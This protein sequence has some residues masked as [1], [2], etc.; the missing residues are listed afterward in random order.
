MITD[1][2]QRRTF[3]IRTLGCKINQYESQALREAWLARGWSEV[4]M[5]RAR[6]VLF[7]SC[8]VTADAVRTLRG[9]VRQVRR[10]NQEAEIVITG[11][12]AQVLSAE[13]ADLA[14][15]ARVV[16][17]DQPRKAGLASY[18]DIGP[19]LPKSAFPPLRISGFKRARPVLKIQDG[20]SHGCT[21]C[22]V[23]QGRGPSRSRPMADILT[24]ARRLLA[25][26]FREII[27]GGINLRHFGRDLPG[28]PDL[29]DLLAFLDSELTPEWAGRARLRLS[30][31]DPAQLGGKA[32]DTLAASR[33]VCPHLHLS[34][35][36]LSPEILRSMG[37]G[38]YAPEEI[39]GFLREL[40][41][42]WPTF[43]LGA[44]LLVGFPGET[45]GHFEQ[46]LTAL[47]R[48]PLTYAH[49]FPYSKRPGTRAASMAN[50]VSTREK[51]E[52]VGQLRALAD[53]RK[54]AFMRH[55]LTRNKLA[56]IMEK[57]GRKAELSGICE[58]YVECGFASPPS[59][60]GFKALA[61]GRPLAVADGRMILAPGIENP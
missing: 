42:V 47:D 29:W 53:N 54:A 38:H 26:G 22:I 32:L 34:L 49:V 52:R 35:Q 37:R 51:K 50:Q 43:A 36:S 10:V 61:S 3:A 12:A 18:P 11:C 28:A 9:Q 24:E 15:M 13:M 16:L 57:P 1:M 48:L 27:L 41:K 2:D 5:R 25:S 60:A 59:Q 33:L 46:T 6:I 30:S 8:A 40:E 7:N 19:A 20:C 31:L 14:D 45:E 44:D 55:L 56:V 39:E 4:D 17:V 21:Y 58:F 23:P